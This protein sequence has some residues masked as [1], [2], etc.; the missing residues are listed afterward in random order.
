MDADPRQILEWAWK[1]YRPSIVATSSFQT[2][3]LPLL[4]LISVTVPKLP[5]VFLDTGFHF[6]ETLAFRDRVVEQL[7]INLHIAQPTIGHGGFRRKYGQLYNRDPDL[8]CHI[9][10]VQPMDELLNGIRAWVTGVRRDQTEL[11]EKMT[12]VDK[13][14]PRFVKIAPMLAWD[15]EKISHY[16]EEYDLPRHPLTLRGYRS[17]G[18][19]PCTRK[20]MPSSDDRAGRWSEREKS[21]CGLHEDYW[22][23]AGK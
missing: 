9:N 21:E 4:H 7:G 14:S 5:V 2:Q 10:K 16:I 3:S 17:I 22:N 18:C 12:V 11:R 15:A 20:T 13:S 23:K 8:C 6:P 19:Q 1:E